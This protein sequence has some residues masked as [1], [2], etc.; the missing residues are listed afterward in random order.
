MDGEILTT[1]ALK[2]RTY[3]EL[4]FY[5]QGLLLLFDEYLYQSILICALGI[6]GFSCS[7]IEARAAYSEPVFPKKPATAMSQ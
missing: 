4:I 6:F 1:Y 3:G 7:P 5:A 2:Q